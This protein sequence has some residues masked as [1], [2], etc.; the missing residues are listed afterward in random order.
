[1]NVKHQIVVF[2][3]LL[4]LA[5]NAIMGIFLIKNMSV[6]LAPNLKIVKSVAILNAMS[7]K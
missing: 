5:S 7:V 1:M 3:K 4:E 6:N 2:V